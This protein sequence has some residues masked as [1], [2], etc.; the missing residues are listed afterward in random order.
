[1]LNKVTDLSKSAIYLNFYRLKDALNKSE[2]PKE[3]TIRGYIQEVKEKGYV[4]IENYY[5]REQCERVTAEIDRLIEAYKDKIWVDE[6]EADHRIYGA[7]RISDIVREYHEDPFLR[8]MVKSFHESECEYYFTLAG[9]IE[10]SGQNLG[11]GGGWHRDSV[12]MKQFKSLMYLTDVDEEHGPFQYLRGTQHEQS[13]YNTIQKS[14]I[15]FGQ[16]RLSQ[17]NVDRI[18]ATGDY[19]LDTLTGK[20]GSLVLVD[21]FG[22][23]RGMPIQKG[24]RYALTNY[25]YAKHLFS[26]LLRDKFSKLLVA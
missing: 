12:H 8:D 7:N 16:N 4:V 5:S 21:T 2:S 22:I 23:H 19:Q 26:D 10:A 6:F 25:F 9:R 1:M 15:Q 20:A 3:E 17:E 13:I 11:S 14:G 18:M 24:V